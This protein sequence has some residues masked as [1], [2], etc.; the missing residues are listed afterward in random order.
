MGGEDGGSLDRS[1]GRPTS[2]VPTSSECTSVPV[3]TMGRAIGRRRTAVTDAPDFPTAS[4]AVL[5]PVHSPPSPYTAA[6]A[7]AAP[8]AIA[9]IPRSPFTAIFP[10][11]LGRGAVISIIFQKIFIKI[12]KTRPINPRY[13][14]T[15]GLA[16]GDL[17]DRAPGK[18]SAL[19]G[20][21]SRALNMTVATVVA[22]QVKPI[23]I[24]V[25]QP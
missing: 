12:R 16:G 4:I 24:T 19:S 2:R 1:D 18:P 6:P 10:K 13:A 3:I 7:T 15:L 8:V 22:G 5:P 9:T 25:E 11:L 20:T 17:G 21:L 14:T 23:R